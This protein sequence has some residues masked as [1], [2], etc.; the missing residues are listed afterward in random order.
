VSSVYGFNLNFL[1]SIASTS[2]GYAP[3]SP[4]PCF[5]PK[6]FAPLKSYYSIRYESETDLISFEKV[7]ASFISRRV[8]SVTC[9]IKLV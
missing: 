9:N 5:I 8:T 7:T 4:T 6:T 2:Q 1:L 3:P